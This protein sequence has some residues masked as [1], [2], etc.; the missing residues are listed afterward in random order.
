MII[1]F[2]WILAIIVGTAIGHRKGQAFAAFIIC[3]LLSWIGVL[4]VALSADTRRVPCP[5]CAEPVRERARIC[6]H[7]RLDMP[8]TKRNSPQL[9]HQGGH[10]E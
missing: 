7:C 6:P 2:L 3:L 10:H 8:Q 4:I 9:S 1:A 5:H